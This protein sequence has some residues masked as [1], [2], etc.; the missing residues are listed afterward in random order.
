MTYDRNTLFIVSEYFPNGKLERHIYRVHI[1]ITKTPPKSLPWA[2]RLKISIGVAQGLAFFHSRKNTGLYRGNLTPVKIL[3][4]SFKDT[5]FY[6]FCNYHI[7][8][9]M[10]IAC[11]VYSFGVILLEIL[12]GLEIT[13]INLAKQVIRDDKV[14]MAEVID[15]DLENIYPYEEG[16]PMYKIIKKCLKRHPY[17]RPLMQQVLDNLNAI[18]QI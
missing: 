11:D 4:D 14:F 12:T 16:R 3:L 17:K 8:A 7:H 18:A 10:R 13:R 6:Q 2:T 15:L 5:K 1:N 9:G